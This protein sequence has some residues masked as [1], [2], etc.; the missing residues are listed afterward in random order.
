MG[1]R[2]TA[3]FI[4]DQVSGRPVKVNYLFPP[5]SVFIGVRYSAFNE[6]SI[7]LKKSDI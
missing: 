3:M 5:H 7:F 2:Y 1:R 6:F 4:E